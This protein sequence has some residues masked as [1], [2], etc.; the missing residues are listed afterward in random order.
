[1]R[2][3]ETVAAYLR[4]WLTGRTRP[5]AGRRRRVEAPAPPPPAGSYIELPKAA[6]ARR[7]RQAGRS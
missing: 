2:S 4:A 1:V 6:A 7:A 3:L 5:Y